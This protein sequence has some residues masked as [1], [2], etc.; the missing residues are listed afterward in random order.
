MD[1]IGRND[2]CPCGSGIKYK[3]CCLKSELMPSGSFTIPSGEKINTYAEEDV[4]KYILSSSPEFKDYYEKYRVDLKNIHWIKSTPIVESNLGFQKG[5]KAKM[6][7]LGGKD[8][9]DKLIILEQI[10]PFL[11]DTYMIAHE[12]AHIIILEKGFPGVI[13]I[14]SSDL[15]TD[16]RVARIRV[17]AAMT[18]VIHDILCDSFLLDIGFSLGNLYQNTVEGTI[19][20]W[21]SIKEPSDN[22]YDAYDLAFKYALTNL[23]GTVIEDGKVFLEKYNTFF[24]D[25]FPRIAEEG[26]FILDMIGICGYDTPMELVFLYQELLNSMELNHIFRI[27]VVL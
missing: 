16:E 10:P 27:K 5:Q 6:T 14:L 19:E 1:N 9:L 3:H 2:V 15:S 20:N 12:I 25:K 21:R 4:L 22:S 18:N 24:E 13:P 7:C 23:Q 11:D 26:R 8:S 17:A